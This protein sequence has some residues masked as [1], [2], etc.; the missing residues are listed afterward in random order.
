MV[1]VSNKLP[2]Y[3]LVNDTIKYA[4]FSHFFERCDSATLMSV[5]S[6]AFPIRVAFPNHLSGIVVLPHTLQTGMSDESLLIPTPQ[7][8]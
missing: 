2:G 1:V 6:Q 7:K 3:Q 4:G 8:W 5:R